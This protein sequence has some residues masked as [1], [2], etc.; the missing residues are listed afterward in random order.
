MGLN[1]Y[2]WNPKNSP[3]L[4]KE[5]FFVANKSDNNSS[6]VEKEDDAENGY[7]GEDCNEF[8]FTRA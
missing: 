8:E 4:C 6:W 1:E 2:P 5:A 7:P 3:K